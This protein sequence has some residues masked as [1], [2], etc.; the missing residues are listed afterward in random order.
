MILR[1]ATATDVAVFENF[2]LGE[3]SAPY[4]AEVAEIV[5]QLWP[6]SQD[7]TAR[8]FDRQVHVADDHGT[9]I[10]VVAHHLLADESGQP[11][12]GHRYLM[13]TAIQASH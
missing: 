12:A 2:D 1:P 11:V 13:V 7:A 6:W 9:M 8:E 3:I 10:G 5:R 4:L